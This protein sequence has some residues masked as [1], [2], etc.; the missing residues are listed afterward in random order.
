VNNTASA[1]DFSVQ[2]LDEVYQNG[3]GRNGNANALNTA[4]IKRTWEINK[5]TGNANSG[6]GINLIFDWNADE[7]I[8]T[9][10][11]H[12]L[13][14][15]TGNRWRE[16]TDGAK[17]K[18]VGQR[19][20]TFSGYKGTFSP[21]TILESNAML[22]V[23]WKG[24]AAEKKDKSVVIKWETLTEQ[25]TDKFIV[26]HSVNGKEWK[27][28]GTVKAARN[29]ILTK[30]YDMIHFMP[31]N[32]INY[33]RIQQIDL[34]GKYEFSIIVKLMINSTEIG[35]KILGNPVTN[36]RMQVN[37]GVQEELKVFSLD[38]KPMK[39]LVL[40]EGTN[41]IDVT[42]W[43]KGIYLLKSSTEVKKVVVQ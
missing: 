13:F 4:R 8:S 28:I 12:A 35:M 22:P 36:G 24:V 20:F 37:A 16:E 27:N 25:I 14:H 11:T 6:S 5:S 21:F 38:G 39:Q 9:I 7:E 30:Q 32:G 40:Q 10:N 26:Q 34:D 3:N 1:D 18:A 29:S 31:V 42:S 43:P 2:V 17:E 19:R 15:Y 23:R 33:Y 41:E